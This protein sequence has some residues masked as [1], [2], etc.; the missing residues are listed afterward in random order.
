MRVGVAYGGAAFRHRDNYLRRFPTKE[1]EVTCLHEKDGVVWVGTRLGA[2]R[3]DA[4]SSRL[5]TPEN[6][7]IQSIDEIGGR[8]WIRA[9]EGAFSRMT[10]WFASPSRSSTSAT[11]RKPA[12]LS[13]F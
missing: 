1:I 3:H 5:V 6:L 9:T 13:G 4:H 7:N 2:Y 12:A 10:D 8:L 11:S